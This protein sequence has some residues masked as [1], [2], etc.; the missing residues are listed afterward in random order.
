MPGPVPELE[1]VLV[2]GLGP[3]LGL[4]HEL[5]HRV[6]LA[7]QAVAV[8]CVAVQESDVVAH[9][10]VDVV[11][12]AAEAVAEAAAVVALLVFFGALFASV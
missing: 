12:A 5:L 3:E 11:A 1:R 10:G 4:V 9:A 7:E 8:A 2:L 6:D